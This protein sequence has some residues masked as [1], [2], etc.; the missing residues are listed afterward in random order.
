MNDMTAARS[1]ETFR[2]NFSGIKNEIEKTFV[3]HSGLV[4]DLLAALMANGH[5]LIEGVPGLGKT[6]LVKTLAE[7]LKL[8]FSRIQFTPD[9]M[10]ADIIGSTVL[11]TDSTGGHCL[12]F[13]EGPLV[14]N[15]I[16]ADEIN[17]G[18]PK[19]QS[20]LLEA[21]QEHQVSTGE[22]TIILP[23]PFAVI[24]TQNPIEQEGTYPLPEAELDR[25]MIKLD[26]G[27]PEEADY[28]KILDRTVGTEKADVKTI[29]TGEE[30]IAMQKLARQVIS[31]PEVENYA[32][33]LVMSTQPGSAYAGATANENVIW[34]AGPRAVQALV[35][36]AKTYAI[37]D[38]RAAIAC[39][40]IRRAALPVLRHRLKLNF[41][42]HL[43]GRKAD[44]LLKEI[45]RNLPEQP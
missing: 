42:A 17:R 9:L 26:I 16:L 25:F 11:L 31:A 41:E 1:I 22:K 34:G 8:S 29:C 19:T 28:L 30:I 18:T 7:T 3:G 27:Y 24:A 44:E 23:E 45:I 36:I 32:V 37:L 14:A 35:L 4:T 39:E 20:A 15:F 12:K 43:K 2:R 10:P 13:R 5:V 6:L 33:R 40:D 21:M 38:G